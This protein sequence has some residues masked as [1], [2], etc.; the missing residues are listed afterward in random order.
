[1]NAVEARETAEWLL[2]AAPVAA[3]PDNAVQTNGRRF[4]DAVGELY[5]E[6]WGG[7]VKR[8]GWT[9]RLSKTGIKDSLRHGY[10]RV[11]INA[12]AAVPRV[13]QS[14]R[15]IEK[16]E[17]W[18]G[19]GYDSYSI[20]APIRIG[21]DDYLC[22][23]IINSN[24]DGTFNFYL[25]EVIRKPRGAHHDGMDTTNTPGASTSNIARFLKKVKP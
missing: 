7:Q 17:N 13:I 2:T 19:R 15:I 6:K 10:G 8:G 18:K 25:H 3:I 16:N 9:V 5:K 4:A 20:A 21:T 1:M 24:K 23:V 22:E 14:G 12:F 11:K